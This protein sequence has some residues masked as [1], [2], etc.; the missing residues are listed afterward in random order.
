MSLG[1]KVAR[2][3]GRVSLFEVVGTSHWQED[4]SS[5]WLGTGQIDKVGDIKSDIVMA[6]R[7]NSTPGDL[8]AQCSSGSFIF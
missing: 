6:L 8:P 4:V 3:G 2:S 5:L 7:A 1:W